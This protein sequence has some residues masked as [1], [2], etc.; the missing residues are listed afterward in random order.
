MRIEKIAPRAAILIESMRDFGYSLETALADIV[1]NAITAGATAIRLFTSTDKASPQIAILDDGRGMDLDEILEAMRLG[2]KSPL[3]ERDQT[4]LGR[5]GLGLKTASFSQC[6]RLTVVSKK[7]GSASAAIWDLDRVAQLDE[8]LVEIPDHPETIPW[9]D[10]LGE[11]GTLV[12][13][14]NPDRIVQDGSDEAWK[15]FTKRMDDARSHLELVFHRFLAGEPGRRKIQMFLNERP[16][17]PFDPFHSNHPATHADPEERIKVGTHEV[18]IQTFTLPHHKKVAPDEWER[19]AGP[20]GYVKNQGFYVYRQRRLIIYGTWF[21]LARQTEL[22]KLARVRIDMPNDLDADWKIDV[23]KASAQPP[24]QV[25]EKLR[26]LIEI[27]GANSKTIYKK[28]GHKLLS[29]NR[30]PVWDRVQDKGEIFYRINADYPMVAEFSSRLPDGLKADFLRVLEVAGS[31]LPMDALFADLG[32][33]PNKVAGNSISDESLHQALQAA[34]KRLKDGQ[35]GLPEIKEVLQF[36]E[37]F[38]SN[39]ERTEPLLEQLT[40]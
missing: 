17:E 33:S 25:R 39:W 9:V 11:Q 31:A 27:L 28:K 6:R 19:Y 3:E 4:D 35:V 37:P 36:V 26:N 32:N 8:W 21:G 15:H 22:T 7:Q 23:K 10:M 30:L 13:W 12:L 16:L 5:F 1:D 38:R 14:E 40:E 2:S 20:A 18:T 29:E 24:Y 34:V